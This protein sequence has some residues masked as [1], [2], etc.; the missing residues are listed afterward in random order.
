MNGPA[1]F[2]L[3]V[4]MVALLALPRRLALLPLLLGA[5]YV[6]LGQRFHLGPFA[7]TF[8]RTLLA[9]AYVRVLIRR[10]RLPNRLT[11]LD[12]MVLLWGGWS[13]FSS[14]FHVD[15][16]GALIFQ[17]G[18]VYNTM[19]IY[20]LT[21]I[22]YR[23][24]EDV[25]HLI[26]IIATV[27]LPVSLEMVF[28]KLSGRNL[29]T[30][31]GYVVE[32]VRDGKMRAQGP[33]AHAIL[34]GTVAAACLPLMVGIWR[35]HPV[36]AKMGLFACVT[37]VM[38]CASSGPIMS[39]AFGCFALALWRW[40]QL[41]GL[42]RMM[43][44]FFYVLVDLVATRPAYFA[45]AAIDLT[46]SSTGWHRAELI[47]SAFAH[48]DEW[49]LAGTD[50]TRHWMTSGVVFSENH[51]DITNHY[52]SNGVH[53]GMPQLLLF[54]A[55]LWTGFRYVGSLAKSAPEEA[56]ERSWLAWAL[57]SGLFAH[58]TSCI[59]VSYYDQSFIFLYLTLATISC[60]YACAEEEEAVSAEHSDFEPVEL[61][62]QWVA[63]S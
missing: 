4:N 55:A 10:E 57:G 23:T 24:E 8:I 30:I 34:A 48:L 29:F 49:W 37:M 39:T 62:T 41:T 47:R 2:F 61:P 12:W 18:I 43:A 19:G 20:F 53:G 45:I 22:F 58:A 28:E 1:I 17:L 33:F 16:V 35:R 3:L 51:S 21:R 46:G 11:R 40:R 13:L 36:T 50:Y 38:T 42:F 44:V 15:P 32:N 56:D 14:L 63:R 7:F 54:A 25:V 9:I 60:L 52:L 31:F 59:S 6:T 27:L 26:R 5:C